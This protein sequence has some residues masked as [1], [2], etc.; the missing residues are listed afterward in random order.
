M[1]RTARY[2]LLAYVTAVL[3]VVLIATGSLVYVLLTRQLDEAVNE[4][5]SALG[6]PGPGGFGGLGGP[7]GIGG[8]GDEQAL[9]EGAFIVRTAGT[10]GSFRTSSTPPEFPHEAA[11]E[12]ARAT[13][14]GTDRRTIKVES[15]RYRVLTTV[16]TARLGPGGPRLGPGGP[17][18]KA[19][20]PPESGTP[21][22][23]QEAV[24]VQQVGISL[25][26]RDKQQWVIRLALAGGGGLGMALTALG[27]FFL[28]GRALAPVEASMTRQRRFVSD[29]SHELRTP[30]ALL[31]LE[32]E[33]ESGLEVE[34]RR[35]LLRQIDR[36]GRM[37]EDLLLLAR[38]DE[39]ALPLEREPVPASDLLRTAAAEAGRLAPEARVSLEAPPDEVW[40]SGDADRLHQVLLVLV[41][42]AARVT[43]GGE[44]ISL[45]GRLEGGAVE[46]AVTDGGPGVPLEH[47][48]QV[49]ERF[50]RADKARAR[51]QGGAGLGLAIARDIARAHGGDLRLD[52][53]G[54]PHA[55]FVVRLPALDLA[56]SGALA[57]TTE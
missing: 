37:V 35:P 17:N 11:I 26:E 38:L 24:F 36:L 13:A 4:Q 20:P 47:A 43:P 19:V 18:G 55:R 32:L 1:I 21:G 39:G 49:F 27:A 52:N 44:S 12:A 50:Y 29:A 45:R 8:P 16:V 5:L 41:D 40:V 14:T 46:I 30:L 31:R 22:T 51:A 42:N 34:R 33:R 54:E 28:T 53:P 7:G 9:R 23:S 25:E 57:P 3:A 10:R 15:G 2:R 56:A 48:A 6:R